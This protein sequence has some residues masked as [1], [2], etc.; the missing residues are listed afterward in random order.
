MLESKLSARR[1][2]NSLNPSILAWQY[3]ATYVHIHWSF[4]EW[5]VSIASAQNQDSKYRRLIRRYCVHRCTSDD[6][7]NPRYHRSWRDHCR[8]NDHQ[9][10]YPWYCRSTVNVKWCDCKLII[11][12][13]Y[14]KYFCNDILAL[15]HWLLW[16]KSVAFLNPDSLSHLY[17]RDR[18]EWI[19][20]ERGRKS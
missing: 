11:L 12:L 7:W 5:Q 8:N 19:K 6:P 10:R 14:C 9:W 20:A 18:D 13:L 1:W 2:R 17:A 3:I 16:S 4:P 15:F